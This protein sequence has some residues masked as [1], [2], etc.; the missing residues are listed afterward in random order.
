MHPA[1]HPRD[2][3]APL[4]LLLLRP[5]GV[6]HGIGWSIVAR[7]DETTL[8]LVQTSIQSGT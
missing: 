5:D 3:A 6:G 8:A 1:D 4:P 2:P 7:R